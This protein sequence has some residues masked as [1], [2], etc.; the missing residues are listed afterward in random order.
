MKNRTLIIAIAGTIA[1]VFAAIL[2]LAEGADPAAQH[3]LALEAVVAAVVAIACAVWIL[4]KGG[5]WRW[6]AMAIG[7]PALFVLTDAGVRLLLFL[8]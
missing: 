2:N 8:R 1:A 4:R 3:T 5:N 6:W 7:G